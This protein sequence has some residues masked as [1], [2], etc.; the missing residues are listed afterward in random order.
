MKVS[1]LIDKLEE[2]YFSTGENCIVFCRKCGGEIEPVENVE[3]ATY[4]DGEIKIII[5]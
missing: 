2:I 4:N 3:F 1:E 5:E